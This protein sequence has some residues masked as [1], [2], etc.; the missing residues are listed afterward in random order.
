MSASIPDGAP[1][2]RPKTTI[3]PTLE[4]PEVAIDDPGAHE[5]GMQFGRKHGSSLCA[6]FESQNR[7]PMTMNTSLMP[8][9]AKV[10]PLEGT[11]PQFRS[12]TLRRSTAHRAT[13]KCQ[14][15][16]HTKSN[17]RTPCPMRLKSPA[18]VGLIAQSGCLTPLLEELPSQP[19][20]WRRSSLRKGITI[21]SR[22]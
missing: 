6:D 7:H 17:H 5:L 12:P 2:K 11:P 13:V 16:R 18:G 21:M 4:P 22:E 14:V 9:R 19:R 1:H 8:P 20:C 3:S 15:P 10:A